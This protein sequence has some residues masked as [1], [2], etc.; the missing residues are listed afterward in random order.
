[1]NRLWRELVRCIALALILVGFGSVGGGCV[2]LERGNRRV[3]NLLD[4]NLA[5]KSSTG[6]WAL[7]PLTLPTGCA[8][9]IVDATIVHPAATIDDAWGDTV[10]LLW[11]PR[12]GSSLRTA[13][14]VPLAAIATPAVFLGDWLGRALFALSPRHGGQE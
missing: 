1:M 10:E 7:A 6:R 12:G 9:L 8:A 14:L 4:E 11:A 2:M 3:L 5:P 13:L